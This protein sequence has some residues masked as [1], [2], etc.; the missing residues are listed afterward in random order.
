MPRKK[1]WVQLNLEDVDGKERRVS[2]AYQFT[3]T[4]FRIAREMTREERHLNMERKL[5]P[6]K[7][8][9]T[10]GNVIFC[11]MSEVV[12]NSLMS[13]TEFAE[14]WK[15]LNAK[16]EEEMEARRNDNK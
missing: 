11:F 3:G 2:E 9:F 16:E 15:E 1:G 4:T 6:V 7:L 5:K 10:N 14:R 12:L 8:I 13:P